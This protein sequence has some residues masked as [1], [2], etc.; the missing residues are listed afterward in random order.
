MRYVQS[1]HIK[2]A[3]LET[4][5]DTAQELIENYIF[6]FSSRKERNLNYIYII[7]IL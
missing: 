5:M 6:D 2:I 1:E 3:N 7:Y 4:K